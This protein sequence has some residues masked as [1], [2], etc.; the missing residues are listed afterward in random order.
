VDQ[1]NGYQTQQ[2]GSEVQDVKWIRG[3]VTRLSSGVV[4]S[5][6]ADR[7]G[8]EGKT[9]VCISGVT[10]HLQAQSTGHR[11]FDIALN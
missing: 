4:L 8:H 2:W 11:L 10:G 5:T 9:L 1:G 6:T 3:M 7:Q